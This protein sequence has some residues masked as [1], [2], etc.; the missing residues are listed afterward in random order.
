M[1]NVNFNPFDMDVVTIEVQLGNQIIERNQLPCAFAKQQFMQIV[2]QLANEKRP[3]LVRAIRKDDDDKDNILEF[4]N[5][6]FTN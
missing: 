3:M 6:A 4:K 1:F 5:N 2:K